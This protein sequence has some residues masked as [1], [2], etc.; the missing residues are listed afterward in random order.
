MQSEGLGV[1]EGSGGDRTHRR[2]RSFPLKNGE[3]KGHVIEV[4]GEVHALRHKN[5]LPVQLIWNSEEQEL[6]L[7]KQTLR[8]NTLKEWCSSKL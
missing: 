8:N 1:G 6:H 3:Q 5:I 7:Q 4:R 2:R